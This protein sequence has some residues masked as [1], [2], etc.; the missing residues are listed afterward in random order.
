MGWE[1][2]AYS[3][4]LRGES[5]WSQTEFGLLAALLRVVREAEIKVC[6]TLKNV[7]MPY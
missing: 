6:A 5:P 3:R 4:S 1:M 7:P 2:G